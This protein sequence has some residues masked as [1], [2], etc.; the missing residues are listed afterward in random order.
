MKNK[1]LTR[2]IFFKEIKNNL[3][4]CG[5]QNRFR[6]CITEAVKIR[7]MTPVSTILEYVP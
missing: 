5:H 3:K 2:K 6:H 4:E 7:K 1:I